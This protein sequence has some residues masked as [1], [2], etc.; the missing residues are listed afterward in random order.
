LEE[1]AE[2]ALPAESTVMVG[3]VSWPRAIKGKGQNEVARLAFLMKCFEETL[4]PLQP[5]RQDILEVAVT[6]FN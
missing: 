3:G 1:T 2:T 5:F 4:C 6:V